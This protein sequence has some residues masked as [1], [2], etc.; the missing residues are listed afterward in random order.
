[1]NIC[2]STIA[3]T[4]YIVANADKPKSDIIRKNIDD[5]IDL[6]DL[7]VSS[8]MKD[9]EGPGIKEKSSKTSAPNSSRK[10]N[11]MTVMRP[12]RNRLTTSDIQNITRILL[13]ILKS[14]RRNLE[15]R[16]DQSAGMRHIA[17]ASAVV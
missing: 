15:T 12:A 1:M 2:L 10:A 6:S 8:G 7:P 3:D 13:K 17:S 5:S 14:C 9:N 16:I 11:I 4:A